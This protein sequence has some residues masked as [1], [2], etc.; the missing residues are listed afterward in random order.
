MSKKVKK[1]KRKQSSPQP[2]AQGAPR[3]APEG[4]PQLAPEGAPLSSAPNELV[5][6]SQVM[7]VKNEERH[8]ERALGWAKDI[9]FEQIVIDTGSTDRTVELASM[10]GAR[11]C[12]FKWINDFGA[13]K[14]F[15]MDQAKGNWIAILDADEYMPQ[16]DAKELKSILEKIQSDPELLKKYDGVQN[17]WVQLDDKN[18][19]TSTLTNVRIFK[20]SPLLR[21]K[22]KIH[23]VVEI[24]NK[25]YNAT[26]LRIMH[27]GYAKSVVIDTDKMERNLK[28]LRDELER[29]PDNPRTLIYMA[30]TIISRGT[31]ESRVEAEELFLKALGSNKLKDIP[32]KQLAYDFL[33][34]RFLG[35]IR[36]SDGTKREKEA[37]KLCDAAIADLPGNIDY[38]Y[39]RAVLNNHSGNYKEAWDDLMICEAAFM[40]K[41]SLPS[42][43][44]L[45]PNPMP[46]FYQ[47]KIAAKGLGDESGLVRNET[48]LKSMMM[49]S[50]ADSNIIGSF[51]KSILV[52]GGTAEKTLEELAEVYDLN[53]PKDL[54]FIA[55]AAKDAGAIEF[56]RQVMDMT[57]K[58]MKKDETAFVPIQVK[59]SQEK[60]SQVRLSQC[61]IVKDEEQN[62]ERALSWAKDIAYEQIVVDTGSTDRTVQLAEKLGAKVY[63][64]EWINDFSAA[65]NYAIKQATGDWIAFLDADEYMSAEDATKLINLLESLDNSTGSYSA[66]SNSIGNKDTGSNN[67]TTILQMPWHQLNDNGKVTTIDVQNRVFRNIK[68][69]YYVG[70]IHEYLHGCGEIKYIDDIAIIHTGYAETEF[71]EK[72]KAERNI[73]M[74]R[75]GLET[76][77]NDMTMKAYLADALNSKNVMNDF[78][79]NDDVAEADAI[80][81]EVIK[82]D[83]KIP[84]Y[85]KK[86]SYEYA[87]RKIWDKPKKNRECVE[88]CEKAIKIFPDKPDFYYYCSVKLNEMGEYKK[89]WELLYDL[90]SKISA[91]S[92]RVASTSDGTASSSAAIASDPTG[93]YGQTLIAAQG[94]GDTENIV[95]YAAMILKKDKTLNNILSP[96]I[97]ILLKNGVPMD[98]VLGKLSEIYDIASP[99]DLLFIARAAKDC[100][101][102]EFARLIMTIAGEM[103]G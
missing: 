35:D 102:T 81:S 50:K 26:N 32:V 19:V 62:I 71:R 2:K 60:L 93:I 89:A 87:I 61:M 42:T 101:A 82:S 34:P 58:A 52:I 13:A 86:K 78:S 31:E 5:R 6:L 59:P 66:G 75:A 14:N 79:D 36:Y 99:E 90:D 88:L 7:I 44:V 11:V 38:N 65:K 83:E 39:F 95:K 57:T 56:A 76:K 46:L 48:I 24:R 8:I 91:A 96:Y 98:E 97:H 67:E 54:M 49:E 64:F 70:K 85:L 10:L 74:L 20:N 100:G 63:H 23:E 80:F 30:D 68:E 53:D 9:A 16:E 37:L 41:D 94:L 12:Y 17:S 27:T 92:K 84:E 1:K 18:N 25:T 73:E 4:V 28:L 40:S 55:R 21:Y 77:P 3:V 72:G 103:M 51:I 33:I 45:L 47:L 43:K 15:A 69:V 29:E 22:G